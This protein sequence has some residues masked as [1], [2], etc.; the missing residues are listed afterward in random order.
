MFCRSISVNLTEL[1]GIIKNFPFDEKYRKTSN[2]GYRCH[3]K[4][5]K[6]KCHIGFDWG[7][8]I[9]TNVYA[10]HDGNVV[11]AKSKSGY[12]NMIKIKSSENDEYYT[13]YA[14]LKTI[15]VKKEDT[16][17]AGDII[18]KSGNTG[19]GTGAHL[20]WEI[21]KSDKHVDRDDCIEFFKNLGLAT[22]K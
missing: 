19:L 18:G 16:V 9:G 8:P 5:K 15:D 21:R 13:I 12:G 4:L 6:C 7:T 11:E 2:S 17:T 1:S 3:P 20:H 14:H 22:K 10:T